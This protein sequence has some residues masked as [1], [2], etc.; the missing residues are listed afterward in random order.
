MRDESRGVVDVSSKMKIALRFLAPHLKALGTGRI[1]GFT[2]LST[3]SEGW[4]FHMSTAL[5]GEYVE[6]A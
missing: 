5:T 6:A 3:M 2:R 1:L 4:R